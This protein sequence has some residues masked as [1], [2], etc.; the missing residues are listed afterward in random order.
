MAEERRLLQARKGQRISEQGAPQTSSLVR[1]ENLH[2]GTG[3]TPPQQQ[4]LAN[5]H[6]QHIVP[7]RSMRQADDGER[8]VSFTRGL[9]MVDQ[10]DV[11]AHHA[12]NIGHSVAWP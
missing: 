8:E 5:T 6:L 2:D 10:F 9:Y 1:T 4:A 12:I 3:H 11:V 7:A